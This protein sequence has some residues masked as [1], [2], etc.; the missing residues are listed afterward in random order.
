MN[1]IQL[2]IMIGI[3]SVASIVGYIVINSTLFGYAIDES[4]K[5]SALIKDKVESLQK[6]MT[7]ANINDDKGVNIDT[8]F[9]FKRAPEF[10]KIED[11]INTKSNMPVTIASLKG[12]VVLVNFWTYSCINVLRTLPHLEDWDTKYGDSGL[13][14][15]GI[16]TPEFEF[17]KN[18]ENVKS[19]VQRYGIKYPVLQDNVYGTWNAYENSYWPRMYLVDAQGYIRYDK[20]GESDYDRTEKVIQFLLNERN[21]N[22]SIKNINHNSNTY[23]YFDNSKVTHNATNNTVANFLRQPVD[24]SKIQTPELYFG[25]QSSRSA[26]GNPEGFHLGQTIDYFLPSSYTS[27]SM[28]NSS[29][30]PNTIYLEGKWKNNPDN[31]ELQSNTGHILLDYSA[32]SVNIVVGVNSSDKNES[33]VT[34]YENNS[35]I[36]NKSKGIDIGI[37]SKFIANEP[38]LYNIVNHGSY[39]DDSHILLIEIHGKGLQA[40]VFTFG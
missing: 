10:Q 22:K 24:F 7:N 36:S 14:I 21:A 13:V 29:T 6:S 40:Y 3:I 27:S 32:K 23:P 5:K 19:A 26:I 30:K 16:H 4:L 25:N 9:Q 34:V 11:N 15:V 1:L 20:I 39:S 8:M 18:T 28:S 33:Q 2:V 37:N 31:V 12:D 38:R 35:L 17:E